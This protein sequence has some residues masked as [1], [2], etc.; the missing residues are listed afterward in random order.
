[1]TNS[2]EVVAMR[3]V[4]DAQVLFIKSATYKGSLPFSGAFEVGD[5]DDCVRYDEVSKK[6]F[7]TVRCCRDNED[8]HEDSNLELELADFVIESCIGF[9]GDVVSRIRFRAD[10]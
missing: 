6:R 4:S 1:M 10:R 9:Y 2:I 8:E 5:A 3:E 7:V